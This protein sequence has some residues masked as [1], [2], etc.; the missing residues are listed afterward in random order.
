MDSKKKKKKNAVST[1][2]T[3][4]KR[5]KIGL[6]RSSQKVKELDRKGIESRS[7]GADHEIQSFGGAEL[8]MRTPEQT[9]AQKRIN[10]LRVPP[11][12]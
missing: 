11:F 6:A 8:R 5:R 2:R 10:R 4:V 12:E 7:M 9:N 1:S 3:N